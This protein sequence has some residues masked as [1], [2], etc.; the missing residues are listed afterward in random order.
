MLLPKQVVIG[1]QSVE[2]IYLFVFLG[3][4]GW[5]FSI[6]YEGRKDG[7]S[8]EGLFDIAFSSIVVG[9]IVYK[10]LD[11]RINYL[12]IYHPHASLLNINAWLLLIVVSYTST[13]V[14]ILWL[15]RRWK[16]SPYRLFDIYSLASSQLIFFSFLGL[17][18]IYKYS[19]TVPLLI[20]FPLMQVVFPRIRSHKIKSGFIFSL[21]L[22]V[23]AGFM[24]IYYRMEGYLIFSLLLTT[25]GIVNLYFRERRSMIKRNLPRE[26]ISRLK[27]RLL[28]K[29]KDLEEEQQLLIKEDPYLREGRDIGNSNPVDEAILE[30][31]TKNKID[32]RLRAIK[33]SLSQV[34]R[35]LKKI[36]K[37]SYGSSDVS[38]K[39]I[40][41]ARLEA[42][43][44]ATTTV[45]E[46]KKSLK[47]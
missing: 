2:L 5:M 34:M 35:A 1:S 14:P 32:R 10:I 39:A 18:L 19:F 25:I 16:W 30:D 45:T 20:A 36:K 11:A 28:K 27:S 43:P 40:D 12:A 4:V 21:F 31:A 24:A 37:G 26:F 3:F 7:F 41:K 46:S 17:Y 6:W 15:S 29:K 13:F 8:Y 38:G 33:R 22:F 47:K 42:Y 9:T 23:L 44:E